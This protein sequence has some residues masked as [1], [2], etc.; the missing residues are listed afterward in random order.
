MQFAIVAAHGMPRTALQ[1]G[2]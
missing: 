1:I 2:F